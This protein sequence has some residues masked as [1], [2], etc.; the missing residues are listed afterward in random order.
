MVAA[1]EFFTKSYPDASV[2]PLSMRLD[3]LNAAEVIRRYGFV[4]DATDSPATKFLINDTCAALGR[5]FV[6]GGVLGLPDRR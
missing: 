3:E 2:E 4:I 1:A 5:P 6:Y